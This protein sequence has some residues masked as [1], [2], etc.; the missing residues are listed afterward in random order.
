[1][2]VLAE[3][4]AMLLNL[5]LIPIIEI[6]VRQLKQFFLKVIFIKVFKITLTF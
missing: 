4:I 1:M 2:G 6:A 5:L 3:V